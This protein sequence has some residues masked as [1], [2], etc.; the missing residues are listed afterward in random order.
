[1]PCWVFLDCGV[2]H[3]LKWRRGDNDEPHDRA[4]LWNMLGLAWTIKNLPELNTLGKA[5]QKA[6]K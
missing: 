4:F 5:Y 6:E 2:R 1:M 3:Y